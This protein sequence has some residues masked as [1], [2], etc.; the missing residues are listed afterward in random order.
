M[1]VLVAG[2]FSFVEMGATAG[3]LHARDVACRW[4][5]DAGYDF[6][7]AVAPPFTDGIDWTGT[8]PADYSH[9][10]FV[11]GPFGNGF[12]LTDFL[13]HFANCRLVGLNLS[14]LQPLD[15]W[16][17]FFRLF[18]RDS[19]R[20]SRPDISLLSREPLVPVVGVVLVHPQSEYRD[21]RHE[22]VNA[23]I[24][25]LL[26]ARDASIVDIDTRLD[27]NGTGLRTPAEVESLVA[28]MDVIVT[29][30]LHGTVFA[31]KHGI[32][33]VVIDPIA[34]GAKVLRQAQTLGWSNVLVA[35]AFSADDL[36]RTFDRCLSDDAR[37]EARLCAARAVE[38]LR[39][40]PNEFVA[41][42]SEGEV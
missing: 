13:A 1:K 32:P 9:V 19:S 6:D 4:L 27:E 22:Q 31:L 42:F 36:A 8:D 20:T 23:S 21:A 34:G 41:T 40:L 3:D 28:K 18:E 29:T 33:T 35:D 12:P 25:A 10:L 17:P 24:R 37:K 2:W 5:E 26:A 39:G 38:S 15:E 11:C 14:M 30:R 16:D 7:V